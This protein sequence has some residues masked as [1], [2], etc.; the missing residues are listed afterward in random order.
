MLI[1]RVSYCILIAYAHNR[2]RVAVKR[3]PQH[4]PPWPM[5]G[6]PK[7]TNSRTAVRWA[8]WASL[9]ASALTHDFCPG[10]N[11]FAYWLKHPLAILALAALVSLIIGL[12]VAPQGYVVCGGIATVMGLGII[13]PWVGILG[14]RASL[15]FERRRA[16]EGDRVAAT[17]TVR[18]RMPWPAWGLVLERGFVPVAEQGGPL[19][20][21]ADT[22]SVALALA[23]V[24]G[25]SQCDFGWDF[26]PPC[27]GD[28]PLATPLLT[29]AF[30]F[31]LWK[32][33]RPVAVETRL[34]AWPRI[35][36]LEALPLDQGN[37]WTLGALSNRRSGH[38][39]EVI[40]TRPYRLGDL[41]RHVH[42]AQTARQGQMIVCE[43]QA[44][45]A[46]SVRVVIDTHAASH[47]GSGSDSSLEW[48]LRIAASVCHSLLE[49]DTRLAIELD[50]S[51]LVVE[52]GGAG[53]QR[54]NDTLARFRPEV[55]AT[56]L[57]GRPSLRRTKSH[58]NSSR[59]MEIVVTTSRAAIRW[60][61]TGDGNR[62]LIVLNICRE[63]AQEG[64][65]LENL[66][67]ATWFT[68]EASGDIAAQ[69]RHH[70]GKRCR[71]EW[72]AAQ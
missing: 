20:T 53:E 29:T 15:R 68:L 62:R 2:H 31:G 21:T 55:S 16:R 57:A 61:R 19:T 47:A 54:L 42:W 27:R 35:V 46:S 7:S 52:P 33:K 32:R 22:S 37:S 44:S 3:I 69:L 45:L 26:E 59:E 23:R 40:G 28:Y 50:G 67:Q 11:R 60:S 12:S 39:G 25:F 56:A 34:L 49:H 70:W 6:I 17:L 51:T 38:E 64:S 63:E 13:W 14:V 66:I 4:S 30:P 65:A 43:R 71:D 72:C 24:P 1:F 18:N 9:L 58:R 41:L 48:T 8:G 5:I 10:A 36:P